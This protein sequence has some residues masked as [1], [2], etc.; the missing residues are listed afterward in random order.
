MNTASI[1]ASIAA[2]PTA[3]ILTIAGLFLWHWLDTDAGIFDSVQMTFQDVKVAVSCVDL[4]ASWHY[5][6]RSYDDFLY[7]NPVISLPSGTDFICRLY[8]LDRLRT[9]DYREKKFVN[10]FEKLPAPTQKRIIAWIKEE[11]DGDQLTFSDYIN[12]VYDKV[13]TQDEDS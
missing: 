2:I 4:E 7:D 13:D 12:I 5:A 10:T 6:G 8:E 1:T 9:R 3:I 11:N